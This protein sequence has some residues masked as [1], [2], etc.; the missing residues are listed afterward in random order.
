MKIIN[1]I[2]LWTEQYEDQYE[3]FNGAF[4]VGL[5]TRLILIQENLLLTKSGI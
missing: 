4:V 5:K 2:D 3:C 1:S